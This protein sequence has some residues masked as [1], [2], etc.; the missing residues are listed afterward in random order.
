M[1]TTQEAWVSFETVYTTTGACVRP[2]C[3][4]ISHLPSHLFIR[5]PFFTPHHAVDRRQRAVTVRREF[6]E[7]VASPTETADPFRFPFDPS[8]AAR[9]SSRTEARRCVLRV[10]Q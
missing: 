10:F 8:E 3:N 6:M 5:T 7:A 9:L 4:A 2:E 1:H